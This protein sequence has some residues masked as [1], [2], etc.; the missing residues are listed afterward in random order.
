MKQRSPHYR[1]WI[2]WRDPRRYRVECSR[3]LRAE[4]AAHLARPMGRLVTF[5]DAVRVR[6]EGEVSYAAAVA[7]ARVQMAALRRRAFRRATR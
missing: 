1:A 4:L 5:E 7:R 3:A 6:R 2:E